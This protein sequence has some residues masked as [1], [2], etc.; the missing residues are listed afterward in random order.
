MA[1]VKNRRKLKSAGD[2]RMLLILGLLSAG[3]I[4]T[5]LALSYLLNPREDYLRDSNL[6]KRVESLLTDLTLATTPFNGTSFPLNQ[7]FG[8][9]PIWGSLS[10]GHYFGLKLSS[11]SSIETSLMWFQNELD[12]ENRL[13][14]RH[15]CNQ[16]DRLKSYGWYRHDFNT[17]GEQTIEDGDYR[18]QTSFIKSDAMS[19]G[20]EARV[21]VEFL[22]PAENRMPLSVI[23][24]ITTSQ[25]GEFIKTD[26]LNAEPDSEGRIFSVQGLSKDLGEFKFELK[27][28][29]NPDQLI[30]VGHLSSVIDNN[31]FTVSDYLMQHMQF[32]GNTGEKIIGLPAVPGRRRLDTTQEVNI[33][34]IQLVFSNS[35]SFRVIFS[36]I[37]EEDTE[38]GLNYEKVLNERRMSF[39]K[40]F[41]SLFPLTEF[42]SKV[43][44]SERLVENAAKV[45]LSNMIGGIGYFYGLSFVSNAINTNK[46]APFGPIQL[47]TAV[48]SRSF[49]PRGFLWDEGF[50]NLVISKWDPP[51]SN[52]VIDSWYNIMNTNGWMPREVILGIESMRRVPREFLVQRIADANPPSMFLV[53]E[54]MLDAGTLEKPVLENIY[55]KLK[56]WYSWFNLTQ[57]GPKATTYQWRGRDELSVT[58][59]NPKTLASGLDDYPRASHP[60][61]LEYH[62][63]LRCWMALAARTLAKIARKVR[64][65][66]FEAKLSAEAKLLSD[67]KLLDELHWSEQHGMYCD[68]GFDTAEAELIWVT[69]SRQSGSGKLETYKVLERHSSG[70]PRFGCVPEFGYVSLFPFLLRILDPKSDKLAIVLDKLSDPKELWS[71]YGIRSL[72]KSSRYYNKYNTEHDK[73]YWRGAI[74]IN[75]NYLILASLKHYSQVE[76]PF[77]G[78][79][80]DLF[81]GLKENIVINVLDEFSKSNYFWENYDDQ[82]GRGRGSHPFNGWSSLTLL[83]MSSYLD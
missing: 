15:L 44:L 47:L 17:F 18:L 9:K 55:P 41:D 42:K 68:F 56:M 19:R 4:V 35:S 26:L 66:E 77:R 83:I 36:P 33:Q 53:L 67:N 24:Y 58:M 34:A 13:R 30:H 45:A 12:Q 10:S 80:A 29:S 48:P 25:A 27:L 7:I 82:T 39:D 46:I 8:H 59:L 50:H 65:E 74:W 21:T 60:S 73:P 16:E 37:T 2:K 3:I 20:F 71:P 51:L 22:G 1:P 6:D 61:P 81:I 11:P 63:D 57:K 40:K 28:D 75:L 23:Q 69:K 79:S 54:E 14:I 76:G 78:R 64:D 62:V 31:R 72:S 52:R 32:L 43:N 49:F 38:I 5:A 70:S